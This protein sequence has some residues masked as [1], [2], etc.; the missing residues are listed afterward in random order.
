MAVAKVK[1][2]R[3]NPLYIQAITGIC[4]GAALSAFLPDGENLAARIPPC[5]DIFIQMIKPAL[6]PLI[7]YAM[8]IGG[9]AIA[10]G[11]WETSLDAGALNE[12]LSGVYE[13]SE[14]A[15]EEIF[16]GALEPVAVGNTGHA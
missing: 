3:G 9:A 15:P 10:A 6:A 1:K 2:T 8:G 4:V 14:D 16:D 12:A 5:G 11:K 7:F 13:E